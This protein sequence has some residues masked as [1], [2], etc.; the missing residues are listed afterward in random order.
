MPITPHAIVKRSSVKKPS[1][2]KRKKYLT[3]PISCSALAAWGKCDIMAKRS[4]M[5]YGCTK[6]P[7]KSLH[8]W[9]L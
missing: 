1:I 2:Q 9:K 6:S 8:T 5:S 4:V 7:V 3:V